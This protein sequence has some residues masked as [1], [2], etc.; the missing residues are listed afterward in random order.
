MSLISLHGDLLFLHFFDRLLPALFL[1]SLHRLFVLAEAS[2]AQVIK[3]SGFRRRWTF[4]PSYD[5]FV[6]LVFLTC[7][8]RVVIGDH[9]KPVVVEELL[10]GETVLWLPSEKL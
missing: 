1:R 2:R 7:H 9:F 8:L 10:G 6:L 3:V 5:P 4:G